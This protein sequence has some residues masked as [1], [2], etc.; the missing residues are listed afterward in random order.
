MFIQ[1]ECGSID[2]IVQKPSGSRQFR[3]REAKLHVNVTNVDT[4]VG[5]HSCDGTTAVVHSIRRRT[6]CH[7]SVGEPF[8]TV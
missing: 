7:S 2:R 3:Q 5:L 8:Y 6:V 4:G 1:T